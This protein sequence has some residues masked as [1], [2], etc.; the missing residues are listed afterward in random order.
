[1]PREHYVDQ[2]QQAVDDYYLNFYVR[3]PAYLQMLPEE[4][5]LEISNSLA[6]CAAVLRDAAKNFEGRAA[7][8]RRAGHGHRSSISL[9]NRELDLDVPLSEL[10]GIFWSACGLTGGGLEPCVK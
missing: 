6:L 2:W 3:N 1:M 4:E 5:R 8:G 10:P 7:G 9:F